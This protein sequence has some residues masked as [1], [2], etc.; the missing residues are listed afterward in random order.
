MDDIITA[1]PQI[2]PE[3]VAGLAAMKKKG[4]RVTTDEGSSGEILLHFRF[5]ESEQ[6][7]KFSKDEWQKSGTVEKRIVDKLDI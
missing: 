7:L 3:I 4:Y 6:T 5:G 1:P 2:E